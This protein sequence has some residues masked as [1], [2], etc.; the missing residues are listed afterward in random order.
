MIDLKKIGKNVPKELRMI[1]YGPEGIGKSTFGSMAPDPIFL[2]TEDGLGDIDSPAI[3]QDEDGKPRVAKSFEEVLECIR[4]LATE[5]HDY[6]TL[7]VDT[8]DWLEPL[9]WKATCKRL[10]VSS[11]E[12]P[13]YGRGYVENI[14]EWQ[15]FFD[16]VTY[17][18]DTR[19]MG[20]IMI[21]HSAVTK[22]EDPMHPSYDKSGLKLHKKAA[23]K[24]AEYAD[25]IGFCALRTLLKTE[26]AGFDKTRNLAISTGERVLYLSPTAGCVAKNRCRG[27]PDMIPLDYSEF[28]KYRAASVK[29]NEQTKNKEEN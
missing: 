5:E 7:V 6:R 23:A 17:L 1:I 26:K 28:E 8:L 21:A 9:I 29:P 11:I 14:Q 4:T 15:E 2:L 27:M 16:A 25:V 20:I 10:A 3:P 24:A 18:R 13:G 19:H 12:E 22:I